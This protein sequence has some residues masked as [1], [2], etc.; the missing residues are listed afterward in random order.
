LAFAICDHETPE[1]DARRGDMLEIQ[2]AAYEAMAM[3][4]KWRDAQARDS[5]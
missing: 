2:K 3:M 1:G 5:G 4:R